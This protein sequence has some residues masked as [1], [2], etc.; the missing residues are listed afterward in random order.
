MNPRRIAAAAV[1]AWLVPIPLGAFIHHGI[2]GSVYAGDRSA[3][4]PDA[5]IIRRLSVAYVFQLI[6]FLDVTLIYAELNSPRR[7]VLQ[8]LRFGLLLGV[9]LVSFAVIWNY[10]TQPISVIVGVAE[11]LLNSCEPRSGLSSEYFAGRSGLYRCEESLC[12]AGAGD[13]RQPA[14]VVFEQRARGSRCP[15]C[16]RRSSHFDL[17]CPCRTAGLQSRPR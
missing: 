3:F 2:F 9:A 8:G 6:G 10:V 1:T 12:R 4:R 5:D 16:S 17:R 15:P 14:A 13:F 7:G 11:D